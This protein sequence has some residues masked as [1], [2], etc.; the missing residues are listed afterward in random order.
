MKRTT[1]RALATG[2][3][4]MGLLTCAPDVPAVEQAVPDV[5]SVELTF[6]AQVRY[7]KAWQIGLNSIPG[8]RARSARLAFLE[9]HELPL[10]TCGIRLPFRLPLQGRDPGLRKW[11]IRGQTRQVLANLTAVL[12][13]EHMHLSDVVQVQVFLS[14]LEDFAAMN[15]VYAT[16]FKAPYPARFTVHVARLPRDAR[17]EIGLIAVKAGSQAVR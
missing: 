12:E 1:T 9:L 7:F 15:E 13:A 6:S 14:D 10:P 4:A 8:R 16:A 5:Q 17:I 11:D 3:L 2:A